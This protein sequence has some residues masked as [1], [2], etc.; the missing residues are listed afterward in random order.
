MKHLTILHYL[1]ANYQ[2]SSYVTTQHTHFSSFN[3]AKLITRIIYYCT[4][5]SL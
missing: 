1:A 4:E 3:Q 5:N 2:S